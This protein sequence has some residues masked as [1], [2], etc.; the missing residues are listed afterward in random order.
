LRDDE[1]SRVRLRRKFEGAYGYFRSADYLARCGAPEPEHCRLYVNIHSGSAPEMLR[2]V[3]HYCAVIA[4][5]GV[6]PVVTFVASSEGV[7][8]R[9]SF[10]VRGS[11][12]AW[13]ALCQMAGV[14]RT[15]A[16]RAMLVNRG[17]SCP[18]ITAV[19]GTS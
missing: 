15:C 4:A 7:P 10:R 2:L 5:G 6:T 12:A 11:L 1:R 3:E 8:F 14:F 9:S 18:G 13:P 16:S 17:L 19:S